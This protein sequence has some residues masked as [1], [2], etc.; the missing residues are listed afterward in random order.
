MFLR[1]AAHFRLA[2]WRA[3]QHDALLVAKGAAYSS[4]T[5]LFPGLLALAGILAHQKE[6]ATF[7]HEF[8]I[9]LGIILPPSVAEIAQNYFDPKTHKPIRIVYSAGTVA[10]F[11]A[12]GVLISWMQGFRRAFGIEK[13]PWGLVHERLVALA[14]VPSAL[15]PMFCAT[16]LVAFGNQIETWISLRVMGELRPILFL[17]W[18]VVRWAIALLTSVLV[19][20]LIYHFAIPRTQTWRRVL[21]GAALAT[22]LWFPITLIFGWYVTHYANYTAIYGSLAAAI[23]LLVWLYI[24][25]L[26]V[27]L[28]AEFNATVFPRAAPALPTSDQHA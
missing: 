11:A 16:L 9:G 22:A 17:V 7:L 23:A 2:L 27:L 21:P 15:V 28:G 5:T 20:A 25:S 8:S 26:L 24:L 18:M 10:L 6:T 1:G 13:N 4:M 3:V 14:L 12:T 19:L